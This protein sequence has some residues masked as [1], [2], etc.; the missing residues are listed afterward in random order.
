MTRAVRRRIIVGALLV[1]VAG[2]A[3]GAP[4]SSLY[5]AEESAASATPSL[6]ALGAEIHRLV[7][8]HRARTGL[9]A[10]RW[11]DDVA[12]VA[13]RHSREMA[14]GGRPFGHQG[15]DARAA[16]IQ[17]LGT[18]AQIAENVA[19]DN[20]TGPQLPAQVVEGWLSSTGHRRNL[21][22]DFTVTGIGVAESSDGVRFFTQI[23]V[24]HR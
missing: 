22:G 24:Q 18:V 2:C 20:R 10:L 11:D 23:F 8:G 7:N 16:E 17:Q 13:Q 5:S 3:T 1:G 12:T 21:E 19:D 9:P 4:S 14:R 6:E 15:F